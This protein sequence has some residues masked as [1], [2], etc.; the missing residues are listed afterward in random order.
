MYFFPSSLPHQSGTSNWRTR[1]AQIT[2][3]IWVTAT[4]QMMTGRCLRPR[5]GV[6]NYAQDCRRRGREGCR[7]SVVSELG[8]RHHSVCPARNSCPESPEAELEAL[9]G[10]LYTA[11]PTPLTLS[12]DQSVTQRLGYVT[13]THTHMQTHR[14]GCEGPLQQALIKSCS[15]ALLLL[16]PCDWCL[17]SLAVTNTDW[18]QTLNDFGP[19]LFKDGSLLCPQ[20]TCACS[21]QI[22]GLRVLQLNV[23][24]DNGETAARAKRDV[25]LTSQPPPRQ[26]RDRAGRCLLFQLVSRLH[27]EKQNQTLCRGHLDIYFSHLQHGFHITLQC[28]S[29]T[30]N[31]TMQK[32]HDALQ[33]KD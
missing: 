9:G 12:R 26:E 25:Q 24:S 3:E 30:K 4:R 23:G 29:Q 33:C 8:P 14:R 31:L 20:Q 6:Y 10:K 28:T 32:S 11:P 21:W 27:G 15:W 22:S 18:S 2:L 1:R 17:A 19:N 7:A 5:A 16:S 13:H